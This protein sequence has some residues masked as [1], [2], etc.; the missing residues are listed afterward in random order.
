MDKNSAYTMIPNQRNFIKA[1][2][3]FR[4]VNYSYLNKS[5]L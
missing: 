4:F 2:N 5:E 1:G 3:S